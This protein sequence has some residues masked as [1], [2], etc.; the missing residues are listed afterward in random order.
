MLCR[1]GTTSE[2][3]FHSR[4]LR[5]DE[6]RRERTTVHSRLVFEERLFVGDVPTRLYIP[7]AAVGLLL[8]GHGGGHSKDGARFVGL[9]RYYAAQTGLAVACI[10]A[11][12][13]GER[14]RGGASGDLPHGWH[15]RSTPQMLA[16]WQ[17]VVDHLSPVGP[18]VAYVGFSMGAVF[19]FPTVAALPTVTAAVFVAG[20]IP[21]GTWTNDPDLASGLTGAAAQLGNANVLMLNKEDDELFPVEGVRLLFDS[22]AALSKRL[23]FSP[24]GHDTWGADLIARSATFLEEHAWSRGHGL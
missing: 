21:G 9:S 2:P 19:G 18:P 4:R 20:G 3:A 12:D 5:A 24:G 7:D 10:D 14:K 8:L 11:V 6:K 17:A 1:G 23:V 13:H 15:S 22:I 16:D